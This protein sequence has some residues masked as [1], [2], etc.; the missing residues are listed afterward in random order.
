VSRRRDAAG[1][2][3]QIVVL[4]KS[5]IAGR[6]KTRLCPPLLPNDAAEVA[7]AALADTLDS[8]A[9]T[10]ASRRVLALDG[11]VGEWLPPGF[12]VVP[13]RG[14][15]LGERLAS[16]FDD[17]GGP[18]VLIGMDT[19]QVTPEL[20]DRTMNE[21]VRPGV[22]AV[23][24]LAMDGG[25]WGIGLRR[26]HAGVFAGVP[27]STAVTGERQLRRLRRLG[28]RTLALPRLRD[29][30]VIEDALA[31]ARMVPSSRFSRALDL[32]LAGSRCGVVA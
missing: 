4:A 5:P 32:A 30:D 1:A 27:M 24:G 29:V 21:L 20:L 18:S 22:D 19:P 23:L 25:W 7:E 6:C 12:D 3:V 2:S 8:V 28:F 17:V 26:P 15:G 31:V 14:S 13:Q 11:A 10:R 9:R 16:A